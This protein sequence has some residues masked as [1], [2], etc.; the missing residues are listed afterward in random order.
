MLHLSVSEHLAW[1]YFEF[2]PFIAF[3]A[4]VSYLLFDYSLLGVR[5]FP[6]LAGIGI[7]YFCCRIAVEMG[8]KSKAVLFAGIS[9]LAFAPFYR[10]HTL[11]Q[12]NAFDQFFWILGFYFLV[13]YLNTEDK[14]HLFFLGF[15]AGLGLMN[16]YTMLFWGLGITVGLLFFKK[17]KVFKSKWLYI[18][19]LIAFMVFLPNIIWQIQNGIPFFD[20]VK[21]LNESHFSEQGTWDFLLEFL[22]I[23]P[24]Q[25]LSI[26]GLLA[27]FGNPRL[28]KYK[29]LGIAFLVIFFSMW[30]MNAKPYYFFSAYPIIFSIA[31]VQIE[32]WLDRRPGWYYAALTSLLVPVVY[33]IPMMTPILPI[34][35]YTSWYDVPEENGRYELTGDYADMFGWEEQVALVDSVY[36]SLPDSIR[37]NTQIWAENYGEAGALKILGDKYGLPDPISRHG[38]FWS[39]G[40]GNPNADLWITL[41]NEEGAVN[42]AF[43]SCVLV[44]MVYHPYAIDEENG[45]PV[46]ICQDPKVDIPRWWAD[47]RPYIFD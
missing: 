20:H 21:E 14:K 16:K 11:F 28:K 3:V 47:F 12:P 29:T 42:G 45:I 6:T 39:W 34:E 7:I 8:G 24:A 22:F 32:R 10:N 44:K 30:Y 4:K 41:G 46:Y 40:Y 18:S 43:N 17:G 33:L 5:L 15:I 13:R 19:G 31:A 38:T 35:T 1:G 23:P 9:I 36:Q 26:I 37:T 25:V 27:V 2:P